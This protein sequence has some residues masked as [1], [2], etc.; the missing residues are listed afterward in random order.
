MA[1]LP[2]YFKDYLSAISPTAEHEGRFSQAHR[3]LKERLEADR[4]LNPIIEKSFQQGSVR[5]GMALAPTATSR[6]DVDVVVVTTLENESPEA[7]IERF[8]PFVR[9]NSPGH[10]DRQWRSIG[11]VDPACDV[12]VDLVVMKRTARGGLQVPDLLH[13]RWLDAD[14]EAQHEATSLK[15]RVTNGHYTGV[16]RVLKHLRRIGDSFPRRPKSYPLEHL[17]WLACPDDITSLAE[18]VVRTLE[19]LWERFGAHAQQGVTPTVWNHGG[20][21][22]VLD[23]VEA[24]DFA[25]FIQRLHNAEEQARRAFDEADADASARLWADLLGEGFPRPGPAAVPGL[26]GGRFG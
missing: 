5:R 16:V 22:D 7:A 18:G 12:D 21:H 17:V 19:D 26:A 11:L 10:W 2:G 3:T 14:P 25:A 6:P 15:N 4:D 13:N 9:Q 23:Q 8:V 20:G 24:G 1:K